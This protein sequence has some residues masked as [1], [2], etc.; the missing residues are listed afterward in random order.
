MSNREK[1]PTN[2]FVLRTRI[3]ACRLLC[4]PGSDSGYV[5]GKKKPKSFLGIW[6]GLCILYGKDTVLAMLPFV[7]A[8]SNIIATCQGITVV[9]GQGGK[10]WLY[11]YRHCNIII[12]K[13]S[14]N[15]QLLQRVD[16]SCL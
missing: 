9:K 15:C 2:I 10:Q 8:W 14:K 4:L 3:T 6:W 16:S 13:C 11:R 5:P 12:L 1:V 7:S